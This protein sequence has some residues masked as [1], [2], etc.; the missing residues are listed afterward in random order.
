ME[1]LGLRGVKMDTEITREILERKIDF[2]ES[3]YRFLEE[4]LQ[5]YDMTQKKADEIKDRMERID[6]Q[7]SEIGG[8]FDIS[9]LDYDLLLDDD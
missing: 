9:K 5:N 6:D 7:I 8:A 2:L 3:R 1:C 4:S